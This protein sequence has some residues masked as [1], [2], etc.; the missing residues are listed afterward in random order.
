MK[1]YHDSKGKPS[2]MRIVTMF[3]GITGCVAVLSGIVAMFIGLTEAVP[4]AGIGAGMTGLGEV[5]KAWQS[6]GE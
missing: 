2:T 6:K 3:A 1:W 4:I 5:A